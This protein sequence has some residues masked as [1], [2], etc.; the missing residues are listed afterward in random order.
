[1]P[2]YRFTHIY[3]EIFSALQHGVN[4]LVHRYDK[5][6]PEPAEGSTVVLS[7]SDEIETLTLLDHPHLELL[8]D[9]VSAEAAALPG[10]NVEHPDG[11]NAPPDPADDDTDPSPAKP[12]RRKP[13]TDPTE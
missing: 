9:D 12:R 8:A 11:H 6:T 3:P 13:T 7:P 10:V 5:D 2:R 1:M 4:A